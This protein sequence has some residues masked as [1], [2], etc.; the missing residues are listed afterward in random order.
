MRNGRNIQLTKQIGEY[1]VACELARRGY[2]SSTFS[3]N[4]PEF[5]IVATNIDRITKLIQVKT[6]NSGS[7]QFSIDR[8][9]EIKMD[10]NKQIVGKKIQQPIKG[11]IC[12][13]V[14]LGKKY[15]DDKFYILFWDEV[16]KILIENH[17]KYIDK[18]GGERPRAKESTHTAMQL[19][20]VEKY[21]N[22]W[23]IIES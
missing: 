15:G 17:K 19:S 13:F 11:L 8:F 6:I 2:L 16:Q 23:E 1:L 4:I 7:W 12:V 20:D 18:H 5:D 9:V 21:G 22:N 14:L 3:G 10:G